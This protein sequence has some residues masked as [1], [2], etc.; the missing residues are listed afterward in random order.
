MD[1]T[2]T[3]PLVVD[4]YFE[5]EIQTHHLD[6]TEKGKEALKSDATKTALVQ[7]AG[8]CLMTEC[9]CIYRV[10]AGSVKYK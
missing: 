3:C 5:E 7:L 10:M 6:L 9:N 1:N 8:T 4:G 2:N